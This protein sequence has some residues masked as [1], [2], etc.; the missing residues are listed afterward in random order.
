MEMA[1]PL[2]SSLDNAPAIIKLSRSDR[3]SQLTDLRAVG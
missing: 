3:F 1:F 2:L